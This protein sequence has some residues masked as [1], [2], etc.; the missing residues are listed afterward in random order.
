MVTLLQ[1]MIGRQLLQ[2]DF[3]RQLSSDKAEERRNLRA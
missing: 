2:H 3:D 1:E